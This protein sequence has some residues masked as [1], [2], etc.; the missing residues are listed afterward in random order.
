MR[1]LRSQGTGYLSVQKISEIL[2]M[3]GWW[4]KPLKINRTVL[5]YRGP[6]ALAADALDSMQNLGFYL[7][8]SSPAAVN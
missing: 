7:K 3:G 4:E 2:H 1:S 5:T 6:R 8:R